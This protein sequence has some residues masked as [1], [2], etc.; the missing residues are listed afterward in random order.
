MCMLQG[1]V[2][3]IATVPQVR[4]ASSLADSAVVRTPLPGGV[5]TFVRVVL[6]APPR[7]QV[8]VIGLG[9]VTFG[10]LVVWLWLIRERWLR[11]LRTRS[12]GWKIGLTG[13]TALAITGAASVGVVSWNYTQHNNDFCI[14]CHVMG[15][16]WTRF[17][18]S[19]HR[20]LKCHDCHQQ[21]LFASMRQLYL[22]VA[23]R[24]NEIP[25]HAKVPT[26]ICERCHE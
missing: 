6:N 16:A 5:G 4:P 12:L 10:G 25:P 23:E 1:T 7:V 13:V 24:P 15:S 22:W 26:G 9:I 3:T 8:T 11:W 20:K 19:E 14:G 18:H 17:Q 21:S 2:A